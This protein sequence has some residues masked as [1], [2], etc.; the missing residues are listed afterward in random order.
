VKD[1]AHAIDMCTCGHTSAAHMN[2]NLRP[3]HKCHFCDCDRFTK[4]PLTT[5]DD[6]RQARTP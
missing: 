6:L 5:W 2:H 1:T 3:Y 4:E